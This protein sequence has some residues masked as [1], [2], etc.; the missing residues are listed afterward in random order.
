M[1]VYSTAF[2]HIIQYVLMIIELFPTKAAKFRPALP[3]CPYFNEMCRKQIEFPFS[4][5]K[6][7]DKRRRLV[8]A[9][10]SGIL[11]HFA[12]QLSLSF[13][14]PEIARVFH[15]KHLH[16]RQLCT[17]VC[18]YVCTGWRLVLVLLKSF[19]SLVVSDRYLSVALLHSDR[20]LSD[21]PLHACQDSYYSR[22]YTM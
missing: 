1:F 6:F 21:K 18:T 12:S 14:G 20:K 3:D 19:S 11:V 15:Y 17:H 2:T 10:C 9:Q 22:K 7:G 13:S 4:A 8:L 5:M 16:V